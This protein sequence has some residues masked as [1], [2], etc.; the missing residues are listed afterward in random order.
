MT[1]AEDQDVCCGEG[2]SWAPK[3]KPRVVGCKL[4]SASP[5]FWRLAENRS[6]G[7]PYEPVRPLGDG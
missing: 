3:G 2:G 4:C 7:K 5:T 6:D 1:M